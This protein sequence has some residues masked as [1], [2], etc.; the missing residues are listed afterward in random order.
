[1]RL[2][3]AE[4]RQGIWNLGFHAERTQQRVH[5]VDEDDAGAELGRQA[6]QRPRVPHPVAQPATTGSPQL[7]IGN[8]QCAANGGLSVRRKLG[9][10]TQSNRRLQSIMLACT[11]LQETTIQLQR[12][13]MSSAGPQCAYHFE[14]RV[15][16][17]MARKAAPHSA[18]AARASSVLPVPVHNGS[19][20]W[21]TTPHRMLQLRK[22]SQDSHLCF[23]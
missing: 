13:S 20:T 21:M 22:H 18:A 14:A 8:T 19:R 17:E 12:Q 2:A 5:L 11:L 9:S 1:M 6:E 15:D 10:R 23:H 7:C 16:G 4:S 3:D